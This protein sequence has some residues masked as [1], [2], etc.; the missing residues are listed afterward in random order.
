[1]F[2]LNVVNKARIAFYA[3]V[4]VARS[5]KTTV[6]QITVCMRSESYSEFMY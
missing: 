3:L 5:N 1:M 2:K 6:T 4:A